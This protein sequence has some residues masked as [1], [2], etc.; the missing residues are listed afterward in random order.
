MK[1][2]D[3]VLNVS[4]AITLYYICLTDSK[5]KVWGENIHLNLKRDNSLGHV[6]GRTGKQKQHIHVSVSGIYEAEQT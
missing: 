3:E 1:E 6:V 2:S 5:K 4:V